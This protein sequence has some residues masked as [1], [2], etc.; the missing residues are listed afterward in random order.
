MFN[1]NIFPILVERNFNRLL[2]TDEELKKN[3]QL[4]NDRLKLLNK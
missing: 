2:F 1:S 3:I 4:L